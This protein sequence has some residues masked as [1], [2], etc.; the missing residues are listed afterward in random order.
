MI[1]GF[2]SKLM[3]NSIL[4][5]SIHL[6]DN[7]KHITTY[8]SFIRTLTD[9]WLCFCDGIYHIYEVHMSQHF[10]MLT[11]ICDLKHSSSCTEKEYNELVGSYW[12]FLLSLHVNLFFC[13]LCLVLNFRLLKREMFFHILHD[14]RAIIVFNFSLHR[15]AQIFNTR[16]HGWLNFVQLCMELALCIP[17]LVHPSV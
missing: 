7:W 5:Q 6:L 17:A 1:S 4:C 16:L 14:E 3:Y 9:G 11:N 13:F 8:V 2:S 15:S 10:D 12:L